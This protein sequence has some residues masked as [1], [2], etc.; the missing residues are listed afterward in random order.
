MQIKQAAKNLLHFSKQMEQFKSKRR[1]PKFLMI[2]TAGESAY[3]RGDGIYV[4]PHVCL[5]P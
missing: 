4:V 1:Q 5:E 3:Q 2:I